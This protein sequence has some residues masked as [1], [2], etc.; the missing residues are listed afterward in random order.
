MKTWSTEPTTDYDA[1]NPGTILVGFEVELP[2]GKQEV[3]HVKLVPKSAGKVGKGKITTL[4]S[5][6]E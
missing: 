5:W 1:P 6:G 3:L 2:A 4:A